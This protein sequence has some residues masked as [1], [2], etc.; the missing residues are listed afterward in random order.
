MNGRAEKAATAH[1]QASE[2]SA[3]LPNFSPRGSERS[4]GAAKNSAAG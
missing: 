3:H 1:L 2:A 4:E